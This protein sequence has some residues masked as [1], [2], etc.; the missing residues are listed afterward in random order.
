MSSS[1]TVPGLV[2]LYQWTCTLTRCTAVSPVFVP[3]L[4]RDPGSG[5]KWAL[6]K[7]LKDQI[8]HFDSE[9]ISSAAE[10]SPEPSSR[11]NRI[12]WQLGLW[13]AVPSAN[14]SRRN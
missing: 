11:G 6:S 9:R 2:T 7:R 8:N 3:E 12:A 4:H 5:T 14:R 10:R 1:Q 13:R